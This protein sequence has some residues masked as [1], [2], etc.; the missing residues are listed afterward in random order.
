MSIVRTAVI[1]IVAFFGVDSI[2]EA[3]E[4]PSTASSLRDM[5]GPCSIKMRT[6]A[7]VLSCGAIDQ[8]LGPGT[9]ARS[10]YNK[11]TQRYLVVV[12]D[13]PRKRLLLV[14]NGSGADKSETKDIT[15]RFSSEGSL[16]ANAHVDLSGYA[17]RGIIRVWRSGR[18]W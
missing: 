6:R 8:D 18:P 7:A 14:R 11:D 3:Q 5:A 10:A 1:G 9:A 13:G 16:P 17:S 2:V 12:D 15:A 4:A